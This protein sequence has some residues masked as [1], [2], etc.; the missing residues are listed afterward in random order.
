M[1]IKTALILCAGFGKRLNPITLKI[2]KPLIKVKNLELLEHNINLIVSLGI[3]EIKINTYYLKDEIKNFVQKHS[4]KK[5]IQIIE[6]GD[7]ILDTGGGILNLIKSSQSN[8][9]LIFNPDTLWDLNY[10]ETINYMVDY[11]F[12]NKIKN[13]LMVVNKSNSFDKRF[14]GDFKLNNNKLSKD[15][16]SNYIY[17]GCQII[18]RELFNSFNEEIFSISKIWNK[19]TNKNE[20]YGYEYK[21]SFIHLTDIEIYKKLIKD[22]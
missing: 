20:L 21:G 12:K 15:T 17:T 3:K 18:N 2:P 6:D 16:E 8:D 10:K 9:F 19:Q 22:Q 11:Y 4:Q 14:K 13:L 5:K 1:K 7:S